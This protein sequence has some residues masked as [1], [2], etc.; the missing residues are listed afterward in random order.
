MFNKQ[1]QFTNVLKN[2]K[3]NSFSF[4]SME[5]LS[6]SLNNSKNDYI[7]NG[8]SQNQ[9]NKFGERNQSFYCIDQQTNNFPDNLPEPLIQDSFLDIDEL[10]NL[11]EIDLPMLESPFNPHIELSSLNEKLDTTEKDGLEMKRKRNR[12]AARKYRLRKLFEIQKLQNGIDK[13]EA[14]NMK[15]SEDTKKIREEITA[16]KEKLKEYLEEES[17]TKN[18]DDVIVIVLQE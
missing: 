16:L 8:L 6:S 11:N 12:E 9:A 18:N 2:D 4:P 1:C 13:I 5:F 7:F 10:M 3:I 14:K 15:I 17:S